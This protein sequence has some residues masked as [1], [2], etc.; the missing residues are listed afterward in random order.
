MINCSCPQKFII[1]VLEIC[2]TFQHGFFPPIYAESLLYGEG[3]I[4]KSLL[5]I[6]RW[7]N[8]ATALEIIIGLQFCPKTLLYLLLLCLLYR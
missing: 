2:L 7:R 1:H 6:C 3:W 4:H 5:T 8:S